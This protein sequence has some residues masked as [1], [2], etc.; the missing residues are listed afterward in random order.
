M[1]DLLEALRYISGDRRLVILAV[2]LPNCLSLRKPV[3]IWQADPI[4]HARISQRL[5]VPCDLLVFHRTA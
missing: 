5:S 2:A 3:H 1:R 4:I